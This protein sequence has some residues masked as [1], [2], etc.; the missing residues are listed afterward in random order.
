MAELLD[1]D[2]PLALVA[3]V[4]ED[5]AIA[6][7]DH[8]AADDLSFLDVAHSPLEPILHALLGAVVHL[9]LPPCEALRLPILRLHNA[10]LPPLMDIAG[11][12][13][14]GRP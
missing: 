5:L 1:G 9:P 7:L 4:H 8:P 2:G 14:T 13:A 6:Y 12:A 10:V 3:D 11:A